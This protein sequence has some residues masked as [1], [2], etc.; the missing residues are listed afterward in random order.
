MLTIASDVIME[1]W[2]INLV[3][4]MCALLVCYAFFLFLAISK[5]V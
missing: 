3:T 1:A 5:T 4:L 2:T